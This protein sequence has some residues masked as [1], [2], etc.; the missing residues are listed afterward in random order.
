LPRKDELLIAEEQGFDAAA[1]QS[2]LPRWARLGLIGTGVAFALG[3]AGGV[4]FAD[5]PDTLK[6]TRKDSP[7]TAG[8][9]TPADTAGDTA[10]TAATT[11]TAAG[12][13]VAT[14]TATTAVTTPTETTAVTTPTGE[15]ATA[16]L[17]NET[18]TNTTPTTTA[19]TGLMLGRLFHAGLNEAQSSAVA[20]AVGMREADVMQLSLGQLLRQARA[21][22]LSTLEVANLLQTHASH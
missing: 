13:T 2:R 7:K 6:D 21:A 20:D 11:G 15:D 5:T 4:V 3:S 8:Q 1:S 19:G 22:G 12:E 18:P 16:T 14:D 10:D 9:D 17:T